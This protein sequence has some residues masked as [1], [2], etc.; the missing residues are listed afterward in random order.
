MING[1]TTESAKPSKPLD[2]AMLATAVAAILTLVAY[3]LQLGTS[4]NL[5]LAIV[6]AFG[7]T[8]LLIHLPHTLQA[9]CSWR[10]SLGGTSLVLLAV[11]AAVGLLA[12]T[13]IRPAISLG[14]AVAGLLLGIYRTAR[15]AQSASVRDTLF[16]SIAAIL[17]AYVTICHSWAGVR[18]P[19]ALHQIA[20][21]GNLQWD[22]AWFEAA[23]ISMIQ[24]Y[25]VPS[26]GVHGCPY[27]TYYH[28]SHWFLAG[29]GSLLGVLPIQT[30]CL[31]FPL[32]VMPVYFHQIWIAV[33]AIRRLLKR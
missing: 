11:V 23:I 29:I 22:D 31:F 3:L 1:S 13:P 18:N 25:H 7:I 15:W 19:L 16:L 6:E 28:A 26:V 9:R 32:V 8:C 14:L 24:T 2:A 5:S 30:A 4:P 33:N 12:P 17:L 27:I 10:P 21:R 20:T